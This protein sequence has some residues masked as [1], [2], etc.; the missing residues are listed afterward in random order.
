[1][2]KLRRIRTDRL[3]I[4]TVA[5]ALIFSSAVYYVIQRGKLGDLRLASDKTLL[6]TL[7]ATMVVLA[8][9]LG[10][11]TVRNLARVLAA[12]RGGVLG[13]KLQAR[14][15]FSF[16]L[17]VF[18]PSIVLFGAAI[19]ITRQS[20]EQLAAPGNASALREAARLP[21]WIHGEEQRR[22]R[23][24]AIRLGEDLRARAR[25]ALG[26]SERG[27][28]VD[29][30]EG[31][32]R[33]FD[34][35]AVGL[36]LR[37]ESPL[38]VA[39]ARLGEQ[40]GVRHAE[41]TRVP[42]GFIEGILASGRP[43]SFAERLPVGWRAVA[44]EPIA[45]DGETIGVVWAAVFLPEDVEDLLG[46]LAAANREV[47]AFRD[48]RVPVERLYYALFALIALVVVFAAVW[49]GFFL[50]RQV[51]RP[52]QQ[53]ARGTDALA[54][55]DL[56]FRVRDPGDDEIGQL[57]ISFNHMADE[58]QRNRR[59]LVARRRYIETLL[60]AV[61]AGV[62]SLDGEGRVSTANR[63][64][65]EILRLA[66]IDLGE[67]IERVLGEEREQV[68]RV[69]AS[70]IGTG[71]SERL[72]SEVTIRPEG[73]DVSILVRAERF[74]LPARGEGVLVVLEDLTKLR[75]AERIAAWGEVAQRVAHEIKN[76]LTPIR[77][78][79]ERM[80]RR[81]R[82]TPDGFG[83]V[84]EDGVATIVREVESLR[85]LVG[86]FSRFARM[87][88]V[89]PRQG[90]VRETIREVLGLFRAAHAGVQ[91]VES[92]AD[93][94]PAHRIDPE[95]MRRCMI[96]LLD[97]AIAAAGE[98]ARIEVSARTTG[99]AAGVRIDIADDGPGLA[100]ED[101]ERMFMPEFSR[102]PGGTG[103]GLAIV[104]QIVSDHGGRIRAAENPGG[105]TRIIIELPA[106]LD[107]AGRDED[108]GA[109][110]AGEAGSAVHDE[111]TTESR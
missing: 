51:T 101:R 37:G 86:E 98:R 19:A 83:E 3:A 55:G 43:D 85:A 94:L 12:R 54:R 40:A 7:A 75:R 4:V 47:A 58:I 23:H 107:A 61:P 64:A 65:R 76:P 81:F 111:P 73:R 60:E 20:I 97:N 35:A 59:D 39:N 34:A 31:A 10:F 92:L 1:M 36:A 77:L 5:I 95:S 84:L 62:L 24:M 53:L 16:L 68:S 93:D 78:A 46:Q 42:T 17:L 13:S 67:S 9:G 45:R 56:S 63:A 27:E 22:A 105:G 96:N 102:R 104:H 110:R 18:V 99:R 66:A 87:P 21:A 26:A 74:T 48:R 32:L 6:A 88:Q 28:L 11:M 30:L 108:T 106:V 41:L 44:A 52:I 109:Q 71:S 80:V 82:R 69:L 72:V 49:A 70:M 38:A 91:F 33:R 29:R 89:Q 2:P 14:V 57:A 103:L 79:A 90:D 15:A 100:R 25:P 8:L 50:A